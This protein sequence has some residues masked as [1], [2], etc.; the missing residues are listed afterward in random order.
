MASVGAKAR[1]PSASA[2]AV[3]GRG[4]APSFCRAGVTCCLASFWRSRVRP[5]S[6]VR[7]S[8][9]TLLKVFMTTSAPTGWARVE[10]LGT[11][12]TAFLSG[13]R[14]DLDEDA[15]KRPPVCRPWSGRATRAPEIPH[16]SARTPAHP[17]R[18]ARAAT[19]S[20]PVPRGCHPTPRQPR[21]RRGTSQKRVL[22]PVTTVS[23]EHGRGACTQTTPRAGTRS[24]GGSM[25]KTIR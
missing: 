18:T 10:G 17:D 9:S 7:S 19:L 21:P 14:D 4:R 15:R 13:Q 23:R 6:T 8:V 3:R 11:A 1:C 2:I 22:P 12:T 20:S 24:E 5:S 16:F 25:R